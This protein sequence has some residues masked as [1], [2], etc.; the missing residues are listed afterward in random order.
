[1]S[2]LHFS[3]LKLK[4][5]NSFIGVK[6]SLTRIFVPSLKL[7]FSLFNFASFFLFSK[8]LLQLFLLKKRPIVFLDFDPTSGLP[9]LWQA[10]MSFSSTFK[11]ISDIIEI[12]VFSKFLSSMETSIPL[13][14][15]L[16]ILSYW[17]RK[18]CP[19]SSLSIFGSSLLHFCG[20]FWFFFLQTF[21]YCVF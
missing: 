16:F 11:F 9:N 6:L 1:M 20:K 15:M 18:F 14:T 13:I 21:D 7:C 17:A 10:S 19:V 4:A 8:I 3:F 5:M 12:T 2:S